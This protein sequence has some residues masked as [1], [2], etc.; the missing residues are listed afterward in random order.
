MYIYTYILMH[1]Y[2]CIYK[3]ANIY[4]CVCVCA[5]IYMRKDPQMIRLQ[6]RHLPSF[7]LLKLYLR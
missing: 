1:T 7:W 5:Y 4:I 2:I 6:Q 3:K